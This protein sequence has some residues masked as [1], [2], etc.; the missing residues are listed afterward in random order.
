MA[1]ILCTVT[2][3]ASITHQKGSYGLTRCITIAQQ[4]AWTSGVVV[5]CSK[6][7]QVATALA[8]LYVYC[9]IV[10]ATYVRPIEKLNLTQGTLKWLQDV[11]H[12]RPPQLGE[13][14]RTLF[15][16]TLCSRKD[17]R[18]HWNKQ[19]A[20]HHTGILSIVTFRVA[21]LETTEN[22]ALGNNICEQKRKYTRCYF[23]Q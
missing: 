13:S 12:H 16:G 2:K 14:H 17:L 10:S 15:W 7:P 22:V 23:S 3:Y 4:R 20:A 18:T 6:H 1:R 8:L 11:S 19:I 5:T 21:D 9:C